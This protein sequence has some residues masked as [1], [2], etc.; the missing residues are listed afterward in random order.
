MLCR[1]ALH[2]FIDDSVALPFDFA[3]G[4]ARAKFLGSDLKRQPH[5][6]ID[7]TFDDLEGGN[8]RLGFIGLTAKDAR[9]PLVWHHRDR[10]NGN[11][12]IP[13]AQSVFII[14]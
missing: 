13:V 3:G 10:S 4:E 8:L 9:E 11:R 6:E 7:D 5:N 14:P 12:D 1:N 2:P